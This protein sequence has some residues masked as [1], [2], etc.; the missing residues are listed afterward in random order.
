[1][2][3]MGY[4]EATTRARAHRV[5]ISEV[6]R[7][8]TPS[9]H[10]KIAAKNGG[11]TVKYRCIHVLLIHQPISHFPFRKRLTPNE[12]VEWEMNGKVNQWILHRIASQTC[13]HCGEREL[14]N[15]IDEAKKA[16]ALYNYDLGGSLHIHTL[17]ESTGKVLIK[18][19]ETRMA[20]RSPTHRTHCWKLVCKH[21][22]PI[23]DGAQRDKSRGWLCGAR[24]DR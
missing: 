4:T 12:W 10:R 9:S 5:I 11:G 1:M 7:A 23:H 15:H 14:K 13:L 22:F 16:N 2:M 18:A 19:H 8:H 20:T 21:S 6:M 3:M 17:F 24:D